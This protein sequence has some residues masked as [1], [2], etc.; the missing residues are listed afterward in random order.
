MNVQHVYPSNK[1]LCEMA[2]EIQTASQFNCQHAICGQS[3]SGHARGV[4]IARAR[5]MGNHCVL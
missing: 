2:E 4:A 3:S 5:H 1:T